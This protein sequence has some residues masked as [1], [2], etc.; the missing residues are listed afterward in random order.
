[1]FTLRNGTEAPF[2]TNVYAWS[3]QKRVDG[4]LPDDPVPSPGVS[5]ASLSLRSAADGTPS[6]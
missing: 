3:L 2:S 5:R 1:M 6:A 4:V